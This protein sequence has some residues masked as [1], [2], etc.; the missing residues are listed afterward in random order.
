MDSMGQHH[1]MTCVTLTELCLDLTSN[2]AWPR[3]GRHQLDMA[4]TEQ[5]GR[6]VGQV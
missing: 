3:M 6:P 5:H 4:Q 1:D 2:H